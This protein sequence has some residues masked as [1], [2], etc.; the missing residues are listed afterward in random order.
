MPFSEVD[1]KT[2]SVQ[3]QIGQLSWSDTRPQQADQLTRRDGPGSML[4]A[5]TTSNGFQRGQRRGLWKS[6]QNAVVARKLLEASASSNPVQ[7][8]LGRESR[9]T[10]PSPADPDCVE[11]R[12]IYRPICGQRQR[13]GRIVS[14]TAE[15]S[16]VEQRRSAGS[17]SSRNASPQFTTI[18]LDRNGEL[19]VNGQGAEL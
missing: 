7:V 8:R 2:G 17:I 19:N 18:E 14:I 10:Q 13:I 15:V 6:R 11:T 12:H 5:L 4:A 16:G 9:S 3:R 1:T